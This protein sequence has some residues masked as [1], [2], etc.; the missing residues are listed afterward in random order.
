MKKYII[1][2]TIMVTIFLAACTGN[3]PKKTITS[4][5]QFSKE[6]ALI[7]DTTFTI[8]GISYCAH[9]IN[10]SSNCNGF[11]N[12]IFTMHRDGIQILN[13]PIRS[14]I[15]NGESY[16]IASIYLL[17]KSLYIYEIAD[18]LTNS[19]NS[20]PYVSM[21]TK[22]ITSAFATDTAIANYLLYVYPSPFYKEGPIFLEK[23]EWV[24]MAESIPDS[25]KNDKYKCLM[26]NYGLNAC[27]LATIIKSKL[28][29][30]DLEYLQ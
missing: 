6:V 27:D 13:Y 26:F 16:Q 9:I 21:K 1:I 4:P 24:L 22:N 3:K 2:T 29:K 5:V 20:L 14:V 25:L 28:N 19:R 18:N 15:G 10:Y 7:N 17:D 30:I 8:D 12:S 11:I 23:K